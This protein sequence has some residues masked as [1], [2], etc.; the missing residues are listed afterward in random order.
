MARYIHRKAGRETGSRP[1][2]VLALFLFLLVGFSVLNLFWPKRD[3]SDL[4]NRKL[5][6]LPP[7]SIK[8]LLNGDFL[9]DFSTYMQD[10]VAFRDTWIDLESAFNNLAFGKV[11]KKR[12]FPVT[13]L[14]RP[15]MDRRV[16]VFPAPFIPINPVMQPSGREKLTSFSEK[17][18]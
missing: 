18:S 12:T 17:L 6:Q 11:A 5:A 1:G 4:E 2:A 7:F 13:P 10:Q 16:V 9:Q 15:R 3:M 8:T 14:A